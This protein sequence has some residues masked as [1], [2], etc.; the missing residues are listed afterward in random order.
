MVMYRPES[1]LELTCDVF[2]HLID[3]YESQGGVELKN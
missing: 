1:F 3:F 2:I